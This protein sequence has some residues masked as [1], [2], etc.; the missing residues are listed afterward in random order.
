M[1]A[2]VN[3][4]KNL[5]RILSA[6]PIFL[7]AERKTGVKKT[8]LVAG[9]G[10]GII[11]FGLMHYIAEALTAIAAFAYPAA[12]TVAAIEANNKADDVHWLTYWMVLSLLTT[13]EAITCGWIKAIIPFYTLVKLALCVW[14][15]LPQTQG[16]TVIYKRILQPLVAMYRQSPLYVQTVDGFKKGAD[17]LSK[18]VVSGKASTLNM[19][20]E[21]TVRAVTEEITKK[22]SEATE[23]A[24]TNSKND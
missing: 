19:V 15:F 6:Y 2:I 22:V 21:S 12:M 14:L 23:D 24:D 4:E 13:I 8:R 3:A 20:K 10:G 9:L 7:Q 1:E 11:L 5:D 16:A 18:G 17:L